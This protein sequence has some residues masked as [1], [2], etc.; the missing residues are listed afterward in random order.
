VSVTARTTLTP[1]Q[2]RFLQDQGYLVV[3]SLLD[4]A[5]LARIRRR[6][7]GLVRQTV[8]AWADEPSL[9]T[10]EG[11]VVA[12]FDVTDP[13]FV[14]CHQ[15]PLLA[16]AATLVLAAPWYVD[17]IDLRAP[18]PGCGEQGLHPDFGVR[19]TEGPRPWQVLAAMWCITPFT[20]DSGPLRVIPGSHRRAEPPI[21]MEHG[22][23]TGM[24]PHPDEV[25][26]IAPAGSVVLFNSADL[27]HSGTFNYTPA[28]R[29]GLTVHFNP[30]HL[31][32]PHARSADLH[33]HRG[34]HMDELA[35]QLLEVIHRLEEL[36]D[37]VTPEQ[38]HAAFDETTL[39][40]F[41][42]KWPSLSM[43]AGSLWRMLC[44]ELDT[45][46]TPHHD[47]DLDEV[48]GSD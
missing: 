22:Y 2:R 7:E 35:D 18:I 10:S 25:K 37:S 47:A 6:L 39:Q 20:R 36:R 21:D 4:P 34:N 30:G 24:G 31:G 45:P 29:L 26:I 3:R 38:A 32:P 23:A 19:E 16:D 5:D 13:D 15:H 12:N 14:P 9:D 11:C 42:K 8:A 41:W 40:L 28:A 33:S 48:G 1:R 17:N 27:W 43:W 44:E 46:A